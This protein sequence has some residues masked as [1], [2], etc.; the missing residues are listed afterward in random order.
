[1]FTFHACVV[2]QQQLRI[3]TMPMP[4]QC[5]RLSIGGKEAIKMGHMEESAWDPRRVPD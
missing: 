3:C 5:S 2:A 1:M 4:A